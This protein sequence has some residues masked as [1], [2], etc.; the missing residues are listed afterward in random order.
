MIRTSSKVKADDPVIPPDSLSENSE[1]AWIADNSTNS[2][3][4]NGYWISAEALLWSIK[5]ADVPALASTGTIGPGTAVLFGGQHDS[6][7]RV[8]GRFTA[9]TWL[10]DG[11]TG[12]EASYFFLRGNE[13]F[14]VSSS[15][16]PGSLPLSRPFFNAIT[17]LQDSQ[18]VAVPGISGGSIGI[19]SGSMFQGAEVNFLRNL[20]CCETPCCETDCS[21]KECS[22][23]ESGEA[24][25][26]DASGYRSY[27]LDLIGGFR[28]LG[29]NESLTIAE[30]I[31]FLPGAPFP[32]VPGTTITIIDRFATSNNFYGGQIGARGEWWRDQ[33]F[34][35]VTGKVALGTTHQVVRISGSTDFTIPPGP[36]VQQ[37]GGLL[38]LPTNMGTRSRDVFGVVPEIGFN[39][40]RQVNDNVRV[41]AGYS[42]LYWNSVVRPAD[43]IDYVI[44]PTQLPTPGGPGVL[45]G[46]A[47]PAP[48]FRDTDL[49]AQGINVG[50][51]FR[52]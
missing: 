19:S 4:R 36:T 46:P 11:R 49:W 20:C 16:A 51:E 24:H 48:M 50:V 26:C 9:G 6:D 7:W 18:G 8:G 45:V 44:N 17:G 28:Y 14:N 35:N 31:T 32:I 47:R 39:V 15:G 22:G 1:P 29:L 52:R 12:I 13:N 43:Q 3:G 10:D 42:F 23:G 25:C 40:G 21:Q 27:R 2:G 38:A 30:N 41:F 5:P 33:W 37:P 34:V